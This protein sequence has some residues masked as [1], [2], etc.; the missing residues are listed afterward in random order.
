MEDALILHPPHNGAVFRVIHFE[1][2]NPEVLATLDGKAAFSA[3][4]G[5]GTTSSKARATP[6]CTAP[7]A[8]I[9]QWC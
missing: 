6:S 2:E 5:L 1:P 4:G 9:S 7:T 8:W 3:M